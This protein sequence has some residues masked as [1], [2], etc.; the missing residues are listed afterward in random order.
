MPSSMLNRQILTYFKNCCDGKD[1]QF[2][3][4]L[5]IMTFLRQHN[6]DIDIL[7]TG[8]LSD[9]IDNQNIYFIDFINVLKRYNVTL[10]IEDI[11]ELFE[12][13]ISPAEKEV[14]G[15]VYTP[16]YIREYIVKETLK[17]Y[18]DLELTKIKI[19]D[20]SC[21]C[22]GFFITA[23]L[24]IHKK[25]GNPIHKIISNFYGVDIAS[26]SIDRTRIIL[27]L[28]CLSYN[29]DIVAQP[30]LY[31][32]NSLDFNICLIDEIAQNQGLEVIIGNPPYVSSSKISEESKQ[33]LCNWS[34]ASTGKTDLYL[35]FFQLA[36]ES[37]KPGGTLG[38]ITVNNF[39]RS[40][41]G[42]AF[43]AYMSEHR[44]NLQM[45]DFGSEQVFKGRSTY[46]CICL[47]S[48]AEGNI[49][50]CKKNSHDLVQ[51]CQTDFIY[52]E[53]ENLNDYTGWT[54]CNTTTSNIIR[55]IES[56]GSPLGE[57]FDI[58]N[59]FATLKNDVYLFTP[60]RETKK[61]FILE[62]KGTEYK[63]E[64]GIC[65]KAIKPNI[66]KTDSDIDGNLEY[67]I[68]PY[69]LDT[70]NKPVLIGKDEMELKYPHALAYLRK[71]YEILK[72]RDKESRT[73]ASWYA[74]GRTQALNIIGKKLL[75]PYLADKPYF[76]LTEDE[77][78]LFYNG[79]A[80]V[81]YSTRK[82][83]VLRC[84][85]QS[86][87]F[88]YYIKHTSKPYGGNYFALA[89]NYVKKFGIPKLTE[90]EEDIILNLSQ[91]DLDSYVENL[92]GVNLNI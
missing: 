11:L 70:N 17:K 18:S 6:I 75:F 50:Y 5:I 91:T 37:L 52:L 87:V 90:A 51:I 44:Y 73:Y 38:Y 79:Y 33:L 39:Y 92:Y 20:L 71:N 45:V 74:F 63:I 80:V 88:W 23:A 84:I 16:L 19:G 15:A 64:K 46:T 61:Y 40:L 42:R 3:D 32:A 81:G 60:M 66:L 69:I 59:G 68:F 86:S 8:F 67:I 72:K 82:L 22:G 9:Y 65:R 55:K 47:I 53:Y 62:H 7:N 41:N 34:V 30:N 26:Y 14:N 85:L 83:K 29:E 36:I 58:K 25:T 4:R 35:P 10:S 1:S 27:N 56:T 24:Y 21:G 49:S 89:K 76:V 12:F 57:L 31:Q 13:V 77:S 48:K 2:V 28:L 78:L 54:L 43:R